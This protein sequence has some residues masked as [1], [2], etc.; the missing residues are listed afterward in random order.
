MLSGP[1][2]DDR[3][4]RQSSPS[5]KNCPLCK[6]YLSEPGL[7]LCTP[8]QSTLELCASAATYLDDLA[9][10]H[11]DLSLPQ[12]RLCER[13]EDKSHAAH[14]MLVKTRSAFGPNMIH[15]CWPVKPAALGRGEF[16][17]GL[18]WDAGHARVTQGNSPQIGIVGKYGHWGH[19]I[20]L[21]FGQKWRSRSGQ[22][23]MIRS[24]CCC[25][26][27]YTKGR[28][29]LD[30]LSSGSNYGGGHSSSQADGRVQMI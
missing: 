3:P 20:L 18:V 5:A 8:H 22:K 1:K 29:S 30:D 4:T 27:C 15:Q 17:G 14:A 19:N 6:T 25:C 13:A 12:S 10:P 7:P 24:G 28:L 26:C 23:A 2:D 21:R 11:K 9:A 16:E